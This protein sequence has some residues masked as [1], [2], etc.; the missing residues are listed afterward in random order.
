MW[1]L[2]L[3]PNWIVHVCLIAG[4]LALAASY[5]LMF[6]PFVSRYKTPI[7]AGAIVVLIF[8]VFLEGAIFNDDAW[9]L[10]VAEAEKRAL[11][12]EAKASEENV[13]IVTQV[14]EKIKVIQ[15]NKVLV[16]KKIAAQASTIDA[17]CKVDPS[18]VE[19]LNQAAV[20]VKK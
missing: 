1:L 10:K 3:L 4:L 8:T 15:D 6:I 19:I 20:G 9:R 14:V 17:Q 12:A 18:V 11:A 7:Q 5:I 2:N 16:D 13:R